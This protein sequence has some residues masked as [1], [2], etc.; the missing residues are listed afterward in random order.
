MFCSD[1]NTTKRLCILDVLERDEEALQRGEM[2]E[3]RR[4]LQDQYD[5]QVRQAAETKKQVS[6][7]ITP[8]SSLGY[9][10]TNMYCMRTYGVSYVSSLTRK[11]ERMNK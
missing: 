8:L 9:L 4:R 6:A 7:D 1:N 10:D 2:L 3:S 11:E 5:I